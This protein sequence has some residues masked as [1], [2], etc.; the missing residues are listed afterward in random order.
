MKKGS[1]NYDYKEIQR[2]SGSKLN[3]VGMHVHHLGICGR[4]QEKGPFC[5]MAKNRDIDIFVQQTFG[6]IDRQLN[7]PP[8][9]NRTDFMAT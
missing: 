3:D 4:A 9:P 2:R 8:S 5:R 7:Q 6:Q 1:T